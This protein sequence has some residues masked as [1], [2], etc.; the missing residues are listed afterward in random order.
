MIAKIIIGFVAAI[1]I[2]IMWL[3]MF[4]WTTKAKKV[5]RT[6]PVELF[7]K[8]KVMAG[9]QGL[10]NG[11]LAAGLLW[12]LFIQDPEWSIYVATFFLACVLVAGIYGAVT[13]QKRIL[14]VQAVPA[15]LG[16]LA[17]YFNL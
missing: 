3:E 15:I 8:T 1:H 5:F 17:L 4:A 2:Y 9:N 6:I 13:V 7:E 14:Y 16:L 11:F 12:S 10:Y